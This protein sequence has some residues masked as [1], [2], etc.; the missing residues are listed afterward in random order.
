MTDTP[1]SEILRVVAHLVPK[2]GKAS[3]LAETL[4]AMT[5]EVVTEPGCISYIVHESR[6]KPG[7][8]VMYEAWENDAALETHFKAAPFLAFEARL[9]DLLAEPIKIERLRSLV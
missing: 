3:E 4:V 1:S 8:I 5:P 7:T 2:P 9:D 6:D